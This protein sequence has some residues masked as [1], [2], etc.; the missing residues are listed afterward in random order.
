LSSRPAAEI[1]AITLDVGDTLIKAAPSVGEIYAAVCREHGVSLEP[2][3]CNRVF[4]I[5]W[6]KR[7]VTDGN[8]RDRFTSSERGED[9]YWQDLVT[10]V[11]AECGVDADDVPDLAAFREAFASPASWRIYDDV[12]DALRRLADR[13]YPLAVLS[14][15]DS[16]L[17]RLLD[18]LDLQDHFAGVYVSA[19]E[20]VEKPDRR[21]F[22]IAASGLG[23]EPSA[24]L[25]VGDRLRE[26]YE[27]ARAAGMHALWLDRRGNGEA[28][29]DRIDP[30]HVI[31]GL[32]GI[33]AWLGGA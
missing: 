31:S 21:F 1:R 18:R 2:E 27:G 26:D 16:H 25:H 32:H 6:R 20:G 33:E 29:G 11:M 17:P 14:N 5:V 22:R 13:G 10:E 9:G 30:S 8:G 19:L 24:V 3:R 15:W 23:I 7:S 28:A 4:E 12:H